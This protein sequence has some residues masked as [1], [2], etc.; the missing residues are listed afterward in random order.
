MSKKPEVKSVA[1]AAEA[2]ANEVKSTVVAKT[3]KAAEAVASEVKKP[4]VKEEV[5]KEVEAVKETA[6][7]AVKKAGAKARKTAAKVSK[8]KVQPEVILQ[9]LGNEVDIMAIIEKVKGL[10]VAEGHRESSI[11]TLQVYVKPEE[12][13]AYYVINT[14]MT[15]DVNLF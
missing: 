1:R 9:T 11:K 5:K 4:E 2:M 10:Y 3:T 8:D 12:G 14:K 13:K 7:K 15:G 6:Q